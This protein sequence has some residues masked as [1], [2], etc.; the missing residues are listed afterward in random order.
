M[1]RMFKPATLCLVLLF[2]L[3]RLEATVIYVNINA[4]GT[5]TGTSWA[6]AFNS[7]ASGFGAAIPGDSIWVAQGVYKP[8][9]TTSRTISFVLPNTVK[10]FGGFVGTETSLSQ[11][12]YITNATVLSGDI[13]TPGLQSDNSYHVVTSTGSSSATVLDGFK[14]VS[15]YADFTSSN[16]SIGG[17]IFISASSP[18]IRNCIIQG[19]TANQGGAVAQISSGNSNFV[20]CELIYNTAIP[21]SLTGSGGAVYTFGGTINLSECRI[22]SNSAD[23]GGAI[24]LRGGVTNI[25]RTDISGNSAS[26]GGGAIYGYN[27]DF[28]LNIYNSLIA[29]NYAGTSESAIYAVSSPQRSHRFV[30]CTI[31]DNASVPGSIGCTVLNT[32]S[33][34]DNCLWF[35]NSESVEL[36]ANSSTTHRCFREDINLADPMFVNPGHSSIAPF[37]AVLY[38]YHLRVLSPM[39]DTGDV[40]Y[41][42]PAY[43]LDLDN[44]ARTFG[45][46]VDVGC[47]ENHYCTFS[48]V[49][50]SADSTAVC[51]GTTVTLHANSGTEWLWSTNATADSINVNAAGTYSVAIDSAGCLGNAS[52]TLTLFTPPTPVINYSAP[53]LSTT[54]PYSSYQWLL[55][56]VPINGATSQQ[57]TAFQSGNYAVIV[58]DSLGCSDT[59][60][61]YTVLMLGLAHTP[62][63]T[64][65]VFPNPTSGQINIVSKN[66]SLSGREVCVTDMSGSILIRKTA[67]HDTAI[68]LDISDLAQGVYFI[69]IPGLAKTIRVSKLD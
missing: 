4:T 55:N 24:Y 41:L 53:V 7:L 67:E 61:V 40:T 10:T 52:Y 48:P 1:K 68:H 60:T 17:G 29:G 14:V 62:D 21:V 19:N 22:S 30:N 39:I 8:T 65:D 59:S 28:Y 20:N 45:P 36:L 23:Y 9:T 33:Q 64:F 49:I 35:G 54:L 63:A 6:N 27:Y 42:I 50:S 12:N 57:D 11:R 15:G 31:A 2:I 38:D 43:N 44:N 51:P 34:F 32:G 58:T 46:S 3:T 16:Y 5:N 69:Q 37:E 18:T 26:D 47:Y 25:D 66:H 13:G 56:G